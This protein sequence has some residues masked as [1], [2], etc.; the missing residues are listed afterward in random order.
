MSDIERLLLH[1]SA[2]LS[3]DFSIDSAREVRRRLDTVRNRVPFPPPDTIEQTP[4]RNLFD[5]LELKSH[6]AVL[7]R[8]RWLQGELAEI[9]RELLTALARTQRGHLTAQD[10]EEIDNLLW[11]LRDASTLSGRWTTAAGR[12]NASSPM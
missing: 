5:Y 4:S 6:D 9:D 11:E 3:E 8:T 1:L 10:L 12:C 7:G 2:Y